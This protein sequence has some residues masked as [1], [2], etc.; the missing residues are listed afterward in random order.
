MQLKG[1]PQ[2]ALSSPSAPAHQVNASFTCR[3]LR[4]APPLLAG[5]RS[6]RELDPQCLAAAGRMVDG[7]IHDLID[8]VEQAGDILQDMGGGGEFNM[9]SLIHS[10]HL[11]EM[12]II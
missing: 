2:N 10:F 9:G 8:G 5:V 1:G 3:T 6:N 11:R 7:C 4:T 12:G